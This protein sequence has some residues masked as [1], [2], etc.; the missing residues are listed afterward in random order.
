MVSDRDR[1]RAAAALL[2][3]AG[4]EME[5]TVQGRSMGTTLVAGTR[6]RIVDSRHGDLSAGAVVA[7]LAGG[8]LIG[9]RVVGRSRDRH[10]REALL[11]RGDGCTFCDP[12]IEHTLVVGEVTAWHDAD[13]WRP[14]PPEPRRGPVRTVVA[15]AVLVCVRAISRF[16]VLLASNLHE[17]FLV[18]LTQARVGLSRLRNVQP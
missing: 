1:A 11:T 6:I 8:R 4:G 9:H 2:R 17:R 12:P 13:G 5:S 3:R 10:G 15:A 14:V 16:D 7:F 18:I